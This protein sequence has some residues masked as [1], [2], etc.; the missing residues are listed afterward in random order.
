M[1][2]PREAREGLARVWLALLREQHP[3]ATWVIANDTNSDEDDDPG[4][5]EAGRKGPAT[6]TATPG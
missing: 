4:A 6:L 3:G 1:I 5:E 2:I